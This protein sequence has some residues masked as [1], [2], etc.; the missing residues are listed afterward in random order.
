MDSRTILVRQP[1]SEPDN[2]MTEAP[3]LSRQLASFPWRLRVA[4][5]HTSAAP[6]VQSDGRCTVACR[7]RGAAHSDTPEPFRRLGRIGIIILLIRARRTSPFAL[8]IVRRVMS[9]SVQRNA[10]TAVH[11]FDQHFHCFT[12]GKKG[13]WNTHNVPALWLWSSSTINPRSAD[14]ACCVIF[15]VHARIVRGG[16]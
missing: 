9:A 6:T 2:S 1:Y 13:G 14:T 8:G 4:F 7:K 11:L 12:A 5:S 15:D 10:D 16:V 3:G